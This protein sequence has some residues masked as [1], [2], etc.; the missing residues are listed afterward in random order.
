MESFK[1]PRCGENEMDKDAVMNSLS[2]VFK[3]YICNDCGNDEA[4]NGKKPWK[5]H[6]EM[7]EEMQKD[8]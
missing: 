6:P 3:V 5:T 1:C 2:R 8:W 4:F 7:A